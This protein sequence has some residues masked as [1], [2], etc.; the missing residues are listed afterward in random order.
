M[1]APSNSKSP[2]YDRFKSTEMRTMISDA[3]AW[4]QDHPFKATLSFVFLALGSIPIATALIFILTSAIIGLIGWVVC[5]AA[6]IVG[7]LVILAGFLSIA[8]CCSGC[9]TSVA[10]L[11][12]YTFRTARSAVKAVVPANKRKRKDAGLAVKR[13]GIQE[14]VQSEKEDED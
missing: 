9:A 10:V 8:V 5:Q 12:Y 11:L 1:P 7:T 14:D 6:V 4:S 13:E 2:L 3:T